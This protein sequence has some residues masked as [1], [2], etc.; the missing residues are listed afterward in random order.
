M[1]GQEDPFK[2]SILSGF[3]GYF[4]PAGESGLQGTPEMR[5]LVGSS[6]DEEVP[7][8]RQNCE[9]QGEVAHL[10]LGGPVGAGPML[11]EEWRLPKHYRRALQIAVRMQGKNAA[12]CRSYMNTQK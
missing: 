9:E 5:A 2:R 6:G 7:T 1:E 4:P 3:S 12:R 8:K 10:D 11:T